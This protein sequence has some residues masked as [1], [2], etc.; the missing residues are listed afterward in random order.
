MM[1]RQIRYFQKV[2]ECGNF[3]EAAEECHISQS[4]V[5]QQIKA[6][7]DELGVQLLIRHNRTFSLSKAGE[8]F[9]N[10][11]KTII[12][13]LDQVIKETTTIGKNDDASLRLGYLN[14][15]GSLEFQKAVVE[16]GQKYHKVQ[17]HVM[18]GTHEE[19]Y[20][21]MRSG[22]VDLVFNDQRRAFSDDYKNLLLL[23]TPL[24]AV[25]NS[26][27][28]LAQNDKVDVK[29][30]KNTSCILVASNSQQQ[31][32]MSYFRDIVGIESDFRFASNLSEAN[33]LVAA[34]AG[35]TLFDGI[36]READRE[37]LKIIPLVKRGKP[38]IRTY[39]A[40]WK[41]DNSGY[42]VEEFAD[43]LK[44]QFDR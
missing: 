2:V 43:L 9:Y 4:A 14:G 44:K 33:M 17:I 3:S 7:E 38:I 29:Q 26:L 25:L 27:S 31:N 11:T 15:Y 13:E 41:V 32:E 10:R 12:D 36:K 18:N 5:S 35:Y 1:L 16:F 39:C 8:H 19:L 34:G 37:A 28:P 30:L 40:F 23:K 42:Y 6:L 20:E 22:R 24:A 21:A